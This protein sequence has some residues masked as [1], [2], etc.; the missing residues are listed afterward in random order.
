M[1]WQKMLHGSF[2]NR[3]MKGEQEQTQAGTGSSTYDPAQADFYGKLLSRA[4]DWMSQGGIGQGADYTQSM[5]RN[6]ESA[7]GA[8]Q[9]MM[10]GGYDE[11]AL[12]NA[13]SANAQASTQAFERNVMPT[14]S[15]QANMAGGA[16]GSRR[17]IAEGIAAGDLASSIQQQNAQMIWNAEQQAAQRKVAGAQGMQSLFGQYMGMQN[18]AN[19][20]ANLPMQ[21]LLAYKQLISGNMGGTES[22]TSTQTGKAEAGGGFI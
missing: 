14:I 6:L 19:Q 18:L 1:F 7:G 20:Q 11:Q 12:Q 13:M 3:L 4:E 15:S 8:Y 5:L 17:G 10:S 16:A 22:T 2:D 21:S 9:Q